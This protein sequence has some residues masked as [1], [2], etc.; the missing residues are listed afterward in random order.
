[1]NKKYLVGLWLVGIL[2]LSFASTALLVNYL[3]NQQKVNV[4]VISPLTLSEAVVSFTTI[5][6]NT[7]S[8]DTTIV[9]NAN[10]A[11]TGTMTSTIYNSLGLTCADFDAIN[12]TIDSVESDLLAGCAVIDANNVQLNVYGGPKTWAA[13]G[14]Q[15]ITTEVSFKQNAFGDYNITNQ[16]MI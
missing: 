8:Y 1:M 16:I 12:V 7:V 13:L 9:N 11:I 6:G 4:N 3:S 2:V 10:A 14:T 15:T 5:G